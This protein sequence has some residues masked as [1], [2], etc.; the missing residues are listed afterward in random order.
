[1]KVFV[2]P[3]WRFIV[4]GF[5]YVF[6]FLILSYLFLSFDCFIMFLCAFKVISKVPSHCIASFVPHEI[7]FLQ[8]SKKRKSGFQYG[9]LSGDIW[10]LDAIDKVWSETALADFGGDSRQ[11]RLLELNLK[12]VFFVSLVFDVLFGSSSVLCDWQNSN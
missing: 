10:I 3:K 5:L 12:S 9:I 6:L 2:L 7:C 8:T 11:P 1:M 4:L